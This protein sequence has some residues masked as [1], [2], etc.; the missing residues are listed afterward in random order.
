MEWAEIQFGGS[1]RQYSL[2]S[3]GTIFTD[4][5]GPIDYDEY[6]AYMQLQKKFADDR[7][8]FTGSIRYDKAQILT[9][10]LLQ[11]FH[12]LI[13]LVKTEIIISELLFRQDLETQLHKISI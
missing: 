11:E 1:W 10:I 6:G 8:K 7:L 2:D 3:G 9:E 12:F 13:V 5:D 4:F